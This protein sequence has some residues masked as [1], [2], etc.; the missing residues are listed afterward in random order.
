MTGG[1][2]GH[3]FEKSSSWQSKFPKQAAVHTVQHRSF[4][5]HDADTVLRKARPREATHDQDQSLSEVKECD[6]CPRKEI[7]LT[8]SLYM[9]LSVTRMIKEA[10]YYK[11]EAKDNE[12]KLAKMK[13]EGR[14]PYDVKKFQEVLNESYMMIPDSEQRLKK[15]V[16]DLGLLVESQSWSNESEWLPKAKEILK[17]YQ[18]QEDAVDETKV[19]SLKEGEVF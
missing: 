6:H 14:D 16:S 18:E 10:A 17:Q 2:L 5:F 12:A 7:S 15:C 8:L 4:C 19:D 13:E 9:H 11:N 1:S 3:V